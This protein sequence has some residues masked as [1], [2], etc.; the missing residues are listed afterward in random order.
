MGFASLSSHQDVLSQSVEG[1]K[2]RFEGMASQSDVEVSIAS[3]LQ[4]GL[5][6][7]MRVS[8]LRI[9]AAG[10]SDVVM[11]DAGVALHQLDISLTRSVFGTLAELRALAPG[12]VLDGVPLVEGQTVSARKLPLQIDVAGT[13]LDINRV[14]SDAEPAA[15]RL[16]AQAARLL[17]VKGD[18]IL[19]GAVI[20]LLLTLFGA[21]AATVLT[22]E[23]SLVTRNDSNALMQT[24][25]FVP[26]RNWPIALRAELQNAGLAEIVSVRGDSD[27]LLT[28]KG[29]VPEQKIA[30]LRAVQG[31]FYAQAD[32]PAVVWDIRR[33]AALGALPAIGMVR[34]S[35]PA[36]VILRSGTTVAVGDVLVD[37]WRLE[38][39]APGTLTLTRDGERRTLS[40]K[41]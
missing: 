6:R 24:A 17:K 28:A 35:A 34:L 37:D 14:G 29:T 39:V 40:Y 1:L 23:R 30:D 8:R 2:Q 11:M 33:G 4:A 36:A 32:A 22:S 18:P 41:G 26:D 31:W 12:V 13:R 3:G 27:G 19:I 10:D 20:A 25:A 21:F 15:D 38:S 9:G 7:T 5:S 16:R